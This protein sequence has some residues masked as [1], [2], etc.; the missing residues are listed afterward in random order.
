MASER[1]QAASQDL[2]KTLVRELGEQVGENWSDSS[3]RRMASSLSVA[4]EAFAQ[5]V[6]A[7][8]VELEGL[9]SVGPT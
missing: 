5:Q 4:L 7:E 2:A 3:K 6:L 1:M 9:E 8:V